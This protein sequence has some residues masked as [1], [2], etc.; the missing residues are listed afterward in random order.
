LSPVIAA[1]LFC[2]S[3]V[4]VGQ[5]AFYYWRA[6]IA[7]TAT[8]QVS[9]RVRAAAGIQT[10]SMSSRDFRAILA[11]Y[12]LTPDLTGH[13]RRHRAIRAYYAFVE[14]A[15]RLFP[16]AAGWAEAEMSMC[17]HYAAALLDERLQRNADSATQMRGM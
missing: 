7:N 11:A 4:A 15:G 17:S 8:R 5:F 9:D 14:K 2:I 6:S 1:I 12:D 10:P 16:L 3:S 13:G